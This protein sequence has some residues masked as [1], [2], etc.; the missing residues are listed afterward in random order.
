MFWL[1]TR[2]VARMLVLRT[3]PGLGRCRLCVDMVEDEVA[4]VLAHMSDR[5]GGGAVFTIVALFMLVVVAASP[6]RSK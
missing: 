4:A 1:L 2:P 3:A 5:H 6:K